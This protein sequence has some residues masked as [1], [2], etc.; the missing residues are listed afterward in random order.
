M[1]RLPL[2]TNHAMKN[3]SPLA[4]FIALIFIAAG[5]VGSYMSGCDHIGAFVEGPGLGPIIVFFTWIPALAGIVA[6]VVAIGI[7]SYGRGTD[8]AD[9]PKTQA[10]LPVVPIRLLLVVL[11]LEIFWLIRWYLSW[12][13]R[14]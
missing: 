2:H 6:G 10:P 9:R 11:S 7:S 5:F 12:T 14:E 1:N 4:I 13:H 8:K 3:V